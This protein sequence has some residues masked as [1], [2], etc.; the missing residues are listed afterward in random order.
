MADQAGWQRA[1]E[2][3]LRAAGRHLDVPRASDPTLAVRQ[4][5]QGRTV[6]HGRAPARG[7][8]LLRRP[9]WR[10][11]LVVAVAFVAALF[12]TPQGRAV[13][14]HVLRFAG[15]EL[16][17][18]PGPRLPPGGGG[19]LP[20]QRRESLERARREASFPVLVPAALG[21][22]AEVLVS[23][24][25]RVVSLLYRRAPYGLVRLDEYAGLV[26]PAIFEKFVHLSHVTTVE[27]NHTEGLWI[28]GPHEL[29]YIGRDGTPVTASAR[30][31]TGNTLIWGTGRV[32][33]RLEG[34]VG[35]TTALAI[36][37]SAR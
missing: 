36:A 16:R 7:A 2:A 1:L 17:Q 10:A 8:G 34:N 3:D 15:V 29:V 19:S 9:A 13:I 37:D 32:A 23:D 22:P 4:R 26:S 21:R 30:L 25:G 6:S 24:H 18:E 5:L 20:G 35:K 11:V 31:T 28:H 14:V 33:L 12:A 27:V